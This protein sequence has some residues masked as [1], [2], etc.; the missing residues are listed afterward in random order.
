MTF[1][2]FKNSIILQKMVCYETKFAGNS[3]LKHLSGLSVSIAFSLFE[4]YLII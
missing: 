2:F 4:F 1:F 3:S